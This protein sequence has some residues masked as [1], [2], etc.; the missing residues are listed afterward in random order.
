MTQSSSTMGPA[1]RVR[2]AIDIAKTMHQVL[3]EEPS[4]RRRTLRVANTRQG[5]DGCLAHLP[6]LPSLARW[7]SNPPVTT[8]GRSP[9]GWDRPAVG[10]TSCR[11]WPWRTRVRRATT[12]GTRTTRRMRR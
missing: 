11:P 12:R 9:T 4:G 3:I 6:A 5:V 7:R 8:I 1:G 2:V 10:C